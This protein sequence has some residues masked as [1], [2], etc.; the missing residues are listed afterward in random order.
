[1]GR[2]D[3]GIEDNFFRSGGHSLLAIRLAGKISERLGVQVGL[4]LLFQAPTVARLCAALTEPVQPVAP[5][6]YLLP[7]RTTGAGRPIFFIPGGDGGAGDMTFYARFAD[8]VPDRPFY[9]L[10]STGMKGENRL[11]QPTVERLSAAFI[12]EMRQVQPEGPYDLAGGC[13]GGIIA[14]EMARQLAAA[15][16]DLNRVVLIDTGYPTSY[17]YLRQHVR[18][19]CAQLRFHLQRLLMH[20]N[21]QLGRRGQMIY[22]RISGWIP[23]AERDAHPGHHPGIFVFAATMFRYRV[24]PYSGRLHLILSK[25]FAASAPEKAWGRWA[26]GGTSVTVVPGDHWTYIRDHFE[27]TGAVFRQALEEPN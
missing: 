8:C 21:G 23:F 16:H 7:V 26:A 13:V 20:R 5:W 10:L 14:F 24:K 3:I 22:D 4:R 2:R 1:L 15:G 12:E 27:E 11:L 9:G 19:T 6:C 17:L 25:E 18:R